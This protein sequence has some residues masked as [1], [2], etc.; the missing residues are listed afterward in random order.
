MEKIMRPAAEA[1]PDANGRAIDFDH[2][3]RRVRLGI[4]N[5]SRR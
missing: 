2:L 1:N 4:Q 3:G 5:A